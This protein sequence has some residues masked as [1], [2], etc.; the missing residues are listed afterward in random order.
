MDQH[1]QFKNAVQFNNILKVK[2]L[3]LSKKIDP[4]FNLNISLKFASIKGY[5]EI[6]E[7]LL[8]DPRINPTIPEN[9]SIMLANNNNHEKIVAILWQDQRVKNT[10][11]ENY[12]LLY[13]KLNKKDALKKNIIIF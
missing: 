4:S 5:Y 12:E 1:K 11:E 9:H 2:E 3:L 8:N 10:L 7:L 6:C 13:K